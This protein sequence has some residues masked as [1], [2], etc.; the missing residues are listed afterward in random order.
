M[1]NSLL[2]GSIG[3]MV[4]NFRTFRL[5]YKNFFCIIHNTKNQHENL[6]LI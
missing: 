5:N 1:L 3:I 2:K 4:E 6:I